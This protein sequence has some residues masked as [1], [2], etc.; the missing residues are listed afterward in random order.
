MVTKPGYIYVLTHPSNPNLYKIGVTIREPK[1][2]LAQHNGDYSKAA[3]RV[4][5]ETGQKWELKEYHSVPDPY[6]AE[7]AFWNMTPFPDIPYRYGVEVETMDWAQVQRGLEAAKKAGLRSEQ[8]KAPLRDWV[9]AYTASMRKRLEGR[10]ISL[11]GYVRSMGSGKSN[12]QCNNGHKWRTTPKLVAE[13]QGCPECG[14]GERTPLEIHKMIKAGV[15]C[16]LTHPQKPGLVNIGVG[17]GTLEDIDRSG[18][19]SGWEIHRYRN[20]E[21][22]ALAET[23]MWELLGQPLPHDRRPIKKNLMLAEE[24]FRK[25]HYMIQEEIAFDEIRRKNLEKA[26]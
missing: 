7:K 13:G 26:D 24:L 3:G 9:Y 17:Y 22:V 18:F 20:V 23:L 14:I 10:G 25:L 5:K 12:F 8:P 1:Q 4:V 21:E 15:I 16:L 6:W 11:N 2:R 19:E